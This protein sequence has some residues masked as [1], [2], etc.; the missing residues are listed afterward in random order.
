[1]TIAAAP[2]RSTICLLATAPRRAYEHGDDVCAGRIANRRAWDRVVAE[3]RRSGRQ[4]IPCTI[5]SGRVFG[6]RSRRECRCHSPWRTPCRRPT[7]D[8]EA[9]SRR[10]QDS[11]HERYGTAGPNEIW[12]TDSG[13]RLALNAVGITV[14]RP[15]Q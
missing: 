12:P 2:E 3:R 11:C 10:T 7:S 15:W 6:T 5:T 9:P 4:S 8:S 13:R 14:A 1:M